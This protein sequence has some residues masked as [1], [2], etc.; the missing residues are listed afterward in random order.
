MKNSPGFFK[1]R[2]GFVF[3]VFLAIAGLML[4]YE[5]RAHITLGGNAPLLLLLLLCVGMHL[6]MHGGHSHHDHK[7]EE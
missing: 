4:V 5:H 7:D 2:I 1:T 3:I 6:F